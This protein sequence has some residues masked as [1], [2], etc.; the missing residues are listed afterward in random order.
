MLVGAGV[1]RGILEVT[2]KLVL[3]FPVGQGHHLY[4][5][6]QGFALVPVLEFST[7]NIGPPASGSNIKGYLDPVPENYQSCLTSGKTS[8]IICSEIGKYLDSELETG[9]P[10]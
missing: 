8:T 5:A 3:Q 4:L 9:I 7:S 2:S 6:Q 1:L 10:G